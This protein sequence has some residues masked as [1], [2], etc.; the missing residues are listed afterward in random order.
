[1]PI[2]T[3]TI[4]FTD[5]AGFRTGQTDY[6]P[7]QV[8]GDTSVTRVRVRGG[9]TFES[10]N[11]GPP[12]AVISPINNM[13]HGVQHGPSGYT[14]YATGTPAV[15]DVPTWYEYGAVV[16]AEIELLSVVSSSGDTDIHVARY[17][18]DIDCITQW[19]VPEIEDWYYSVGYLDFTFPLSYEVYVS[20]QVWTALRF[21]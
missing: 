16:P 11:L 2:A 10:A 18:V 13:V 3:Q 20:M 21:T 12:P 7:L 15:D 19:H 14:P 5:F 1:M 4:Q 17:R 9:I 6:G 8:V